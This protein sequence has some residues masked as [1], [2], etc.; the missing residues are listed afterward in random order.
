MDQ[1]AAA[2]LVVLPSLV[3]SL[4]LF[5][6]LQREFAEGHTLSGIKVSGTKG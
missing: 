1:M 5:F 3:L 6:L 4:V 2:T